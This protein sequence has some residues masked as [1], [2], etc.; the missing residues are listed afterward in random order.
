MLST[1]A[2][3]SLGI[4]FVAIAGTNVWLMLRASRTSQGPGR[5]VTLRRLRR[6]GGYLFRDK[7]V[8][9][10][11]LD[12]TFTAGLLSKFTVNGSSS[13]NYSFASSA[14]IIYWVEIFSGASSAQGR[15]SEHAQLY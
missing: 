6:L 8:A 12:F 2:G 11:A 3:V 7:N 15:V 9:A 1:I 5:R 10:A 14:A 4:L 13:F